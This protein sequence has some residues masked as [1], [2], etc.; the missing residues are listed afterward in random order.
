MSWTH[1]SWPWRMSLHL[2]AAAPLAPRAINFPAI[3]SIQR[4]LLINN[5]VYIVYTQHVTMKQINLTTCGAV[6]VRVRNVNACFLEVLQQF[7]LQLVRV[8]PSSCAMDFREQNTRALIMYLWASALNAVYYR[9][10]MIRMLQAFKSTSAQLTPFINQSINQSMCCF[11]A[12]P[13]VTGLELWALNYT[14]IH[15]PSAP[16]ANYFLGNGDRSMS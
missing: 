12:L 14:L 6:N 11:L 3:V 7:Q 5:Y 4:F 9:W 1:D 2:Q 13:F 15:L 8:A 10:F 16:L